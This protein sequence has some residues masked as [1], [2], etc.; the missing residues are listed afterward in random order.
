MY[1]HMY[2][3]GC[4]RETVQKGCVYIHNKEFASVR[5]LIFILIS[6]HIINHVFVYLLLIKLIEMKC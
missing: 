4:Y 2:E 1:M 3:A 6:A 5:I